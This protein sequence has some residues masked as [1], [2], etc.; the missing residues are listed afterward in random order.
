[1]RII[2]FGSIN[3]DLVFR[4]PTLPRPG[5]TVLGPGYTAVPGGKGANQAVAAYR[6]GARVAMV[7]AVG[8]DPFADLALSEMVGIDQGGIDR[9]AAPTGCAAIGVGAD[10]ENLIMV[11]SG[12]NALVSAG[13][14]PE[15]GPDDLLL[16]QMEVPVAE[17]EAALARAKRSGARTLLNCAPAGAIRLGDVDILV[18][19]EQEAEA[20][21]PTDVPVTITTLGS[22]G[23]LVSDRGRRFT[24][25]AMPIK[26]VDTTSAGDC[27]VGVLAASLGMG[28]DRAVRRASVAAGL[29]CLAHGAQSSIPSAAAIEA[30]LDKVA[31]PAS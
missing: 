31:L 13:Q 20:L 16:A 23:A 15:L 9:V 18:V 29:A 2:V 28:L 19:N 24:V 21:G 25:A 22:R 26:P 8:S 5:E 3:L 10:G 11:A 6:A 12:A 4:V 7:G 17:T 30:A 14:L 27:F 1:M